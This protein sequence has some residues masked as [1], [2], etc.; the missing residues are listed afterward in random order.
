MFL[1]EINNEIKGS[2]AAR[3]LEVAFGE[4]APTAWW[5]QKWLKLFKEGKKGIDDLSDEER[6]GRPDDFDEDRLREVVEQDPRVT[7]RELAT[8]LDS[9][10]STVHRH[11]HNIEKVSGWC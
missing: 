6:S 7:V 9:T 3:K 2:D 1:Y 10:H 4:N 11:L 8:L 5:C